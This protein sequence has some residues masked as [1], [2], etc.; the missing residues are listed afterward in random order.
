MSCPPK[1]HN[2]IGYKAPSPKTFTE[3]IKL[4]YILHRLFQLFKTEF[5]IHSL[6]HFTKEPPWSHCD[7]WAGDKEEF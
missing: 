5:F 2:I 4:Y 1:P 6:F 7:W 3:D